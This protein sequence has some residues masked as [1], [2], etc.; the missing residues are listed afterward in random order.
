MA[1]KDSTSVLGFQ[2]SPPVRQ[3]L[4]EYREEQDLNKSEALERATDA[5]LRIKGYDGSNKSVR[6]LRQVVSET[7]KGMLVMAVAWV[8]VSAATS[9]VLYQQAG[10]AALVALACFAAEPRL[11]TIAK[12]LQTEGNDDGGS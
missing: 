11:P 2:P 12:R 7:G 10:I 4:E 5:G 8:A 9:I 3:R 1:S 6:M